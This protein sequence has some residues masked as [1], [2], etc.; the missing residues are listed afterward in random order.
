MK[1]Y[2][3]FRFKGGKLYPLYVFANEEVEIGKTLY[4]KEGVKT[5]DG[6]VRSKL[7]KLAYRPGWHLT[8]FPI[9]DHIGTRQPNGKLYQAKDSIWCEVEVDDSLYN[10]TEDLAK[11]HKNYRD[12]CFHELHKGYYWFKTNA[13]AKVN[14]MIAS[15]MKVI[16]I[17]TNE[18]V[19]TICRAN[20]LEPQPISEI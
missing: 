9:A 17:L 16:R 19:A 10:H 11:A 1:L 6:K 15:E 8:E 5:E 12:R 13:S 4:A 14:W 3:L 20:G 2:K 7:G 18:E